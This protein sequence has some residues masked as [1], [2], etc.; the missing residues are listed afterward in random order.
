MKNNWYLSFKDL[1]YFYPYKL[2]S[3]IQCKLEESEILKMQCSNSMIL[4]K[5]IR[6]NF[7]IEPFMMLQ[8]SW[9]SFTVI[10]QLRNNLSK[11][12]NTNLRELAFF[13][14]QCENDELRKMHSKDWVSNEIVLVTNSIKKL[15]SCYSKPAAKFGMYVKSFQLDVWFSLFLFYSLIAAFISL[16][17]MKLKLSKSF[18]PYFFF[19]RVFKTVTITWLLTAMAITNPYIGLMI[20]DLTSPLQGERLASFDQVLDTEFVVNKMSDLKP[21]EIQHFW[22]NI[23]TH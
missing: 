22:L 18:S 4:Y 6:S 11:I 13:Y 7:R 5:N 8:I 21:W 14:N 12:I 15:L 3:Q 1:S 20:S 23:Y 17:N 10:M 9:V 16:Y 19:V 2:I